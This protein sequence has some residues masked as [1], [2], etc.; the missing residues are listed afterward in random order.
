M[1]AWIQFAVVAVLFIAGLI[2]L[3][4]AIFGTFHFDFALNRIHSAG[5]VDTLALLLFIVGCMIC[6]GLSVTSA[7]FFLILLVQWFT[8]PLVSH[9]LVKAEYLTFDNLRGHC[10]LP[11]ED[12][13]KEEDA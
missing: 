9:L 2:T 7:K 1:L 6:A 4:V 10:E 3:F 5:M 8:S 12:D 11:E 13:H